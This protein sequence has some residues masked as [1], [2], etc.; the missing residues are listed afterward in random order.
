MG[1]DIVRSLIAG[2]ALLL[3]VAVTGAVGVVG[4]SDLA[5]GGVFVTLL[6][7]FGL[8]LFD[9]SWDSVEASGDA[10]A[11]ADFAAEADLLANTAD[12]HST[13]A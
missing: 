8:A 3:L 5:V 2:G 1:G 7:L 6:L 10:V 12:A 9:D 4:L 11:P 13:A